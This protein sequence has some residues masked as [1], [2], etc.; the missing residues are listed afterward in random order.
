MALIA[1]A[2]VGF[3][4]FM[5]GRYNEGASRLYSPT[6][7]VVEKNKA[8]ALN[9]EGETNQVFYALTNNTYV[10]FE[11][12]EKHV[13]IEKMSRLERETEQIEREIKQELKARK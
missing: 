9:S 6:K 3:F 4:G 1:V 2:G 11:Q 8:Y 10:P 7:I 5:A 13:R 12:I